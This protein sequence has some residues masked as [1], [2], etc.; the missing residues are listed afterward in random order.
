MKK[1]K[2]WKGKIKRQVDLNGLFGELSQDFLFG[3]LSIVIYELVS[4]NKNNNNA[5][6]HLCYCIGNQIKFVYIMI[7]LFYH[8]NDPT[9][10]YARPSLTGHK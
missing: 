2:N 8:S 6:N 1:H 7:R 3:I 9:I 4:K 10:D 5:Y